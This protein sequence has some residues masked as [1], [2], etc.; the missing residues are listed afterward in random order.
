MPISDKAIKD[1]PLGDKVEKAIFD[2]IQDWEGAI[3]WSIDHLPD[4]PVG[5]SWLDWSIGLVG[6]MLWA[7]TVFFPPTF[8]IAT[9]TEVAMRGGVLVAGTGKLVYA[10]A[11]AATKAASVLGAAIGSSGTQI[12]GLLRALDGE[13]NSPE[14][15][16]FMHDFMMRQ[17]GEIYQKFVDDADSGPDR[18]AHHGN[19]HSGGLEGPGKR[20]EPDSADRPSD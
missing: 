6:N 11:S 3:E 13:L 7:A 5:F 19:S 16:K 12:G 2:C 4:P 15:K 9:T 20:P 18:N 17:I 10:S 8:V 1:L 14:G